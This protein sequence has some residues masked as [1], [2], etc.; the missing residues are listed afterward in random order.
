MSSLV[1]IVGVVFPQPARH[2]VL[3]RLAGVHPVQRRHVLLTQLEAPHLDNQSQ[4]SIATIDQSEFSIATMDQSQLS[5]VTIDQS[6]LSIV[7]VDQSQLSI[8]PHL[9]VGPHPRLVGRL[10]Q[11][12]AV[13]LHCPPQQHLTTIHIRHVGAV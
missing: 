11:Q 3:P 13:V 2:R 12:R 8:P 10:G 6:Q 1:I 7:S 5:I 4:L 9:L